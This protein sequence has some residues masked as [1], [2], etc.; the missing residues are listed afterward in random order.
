MTTAIVWILAIGLH[1]G[2]QSMGVQIT[3][4]T[5]ARCEAAKASL[6][7]TGAGQVG[8]MCYPKKQDEKP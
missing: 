1:G 5:E 7:T 6:K 4:P 3:F 8:A 2:Y